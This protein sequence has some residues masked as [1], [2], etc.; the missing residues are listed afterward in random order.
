L[1]SSIQSVQTKGDKAHSPDFSKVA[2]DK[3][4]FPENIRAQPSAPTTINWQK[5]A[6]E[7]N[8]PG[9]YCGQVVK[10]FATK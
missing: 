1:N 3:Q 4:A 6:N 7:H 5:S 8:V 10:E 2:W 9:R